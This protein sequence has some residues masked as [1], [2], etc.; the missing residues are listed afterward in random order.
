MT[1]PQRKN[2]LERLLTVFTEVRSG[3]GWVVLLMTVNI[4]LT[5]TAYYIIKPVREALILEDPGGA[6]YKSYATGAIALL[7]LVAVPAYSTLANRL[8]RNRL[9]I[10]VIVFFIACLTAFYLIG[11]SPSLRPHLAIPFYLWVGVF[12]MMIVAQFWAFAND[13]YTVEQGARLFALVGLGQSVG[14]ALGSKLTSVLLQPP[15]WLPI[16][17]LSTYSLLLI[18]AGLLAMTAFI[19]QYVH[20]QQGERSAVQP[21][22]PEQPD[23]PEQPKSPGQGAFALV[24]STRYLA[25]IAAFSLLFTFVNTN[26]E[27]MLSVI[28][29]DAAPAKGEVLDGLSRGAWLGQFYGDFYFW[30]NVV[31]VLMQSLVVSRIIK[32]GGLKVAFMVLPVLA[33]LGSAVVLI[34]P[35]LL[36]LRITKTIENATDYSLNNTARNM[37]WLST[38]KEMKY[39]AKQAVD[40]FF[41]RM[42]DVSSALLVF[43]SASILHLSVRG[44]AGINIVLCIAWIGLARMVL[45]EGDTIATK[46][47]EP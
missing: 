30:V 13:I 46:R 42:G 20:T 8:Q 21:V 24:F 9:I 34:F 12:N 14:A 47:D 32:F 35:I 44:F 5:L 39:K 6:E 27:Y 18:S 15:D 10:G 28:A 36:A 26:G 3:E 22:A 38:T 33:A 41:V 37:L 40:T 7:L 43:A 23:P 17:A 45:S 4:F 25:L 2:A 31:G 11:S 29:S 16:D 19:T 1:T